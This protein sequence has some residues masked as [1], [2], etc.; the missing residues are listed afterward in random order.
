MKV[1]LVY[2]RVNKWGGAERVLLALQKIFPDAPLYTS[3]YNKQKTPWANNFYVITSFLQKIPFL[4]KHELLAPFMPIAFE[5]F[6]FDG[7][8]VVISITSESAK[9]IITK[10]HTKHICICLTPTRYL[11]SGYKEYFSSSLFR[12]ITK[13][14]V[15]Y[16]KKWDKMAS[17]RP[18]IFIAISIEVQQRIQTYYHRTSSVVYPAIDEQFLSSH[19]DSSILKKHHLTQ[20]NYFLVVSR[21]SQFT[22]Y[23]RVDQAIAAANTL[24][25]PLVIAGGGDL[26][27]FKS[28]AGKTVIFTGSIS[29]PQLKA[30]YTNAKAL[31]FPALEDFGL[32][33][34]EMQACGRPVIA[35]GKGGAV[36]IVQP[37]KTGILYKDQ[38][39]ES[40]I[41]ALKSFNEK[42]Y[43]RKYC[44]ENAKKFS[45]E[46]FKKEIQRVIQTR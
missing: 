25:L 40:L 15:W 45:F 34:A 9:G 23:K 28:L 5:Q 37:G 43:N 22:K 7:Y 13:C 39:V 21:L 20:G 31:I 33:M 42:D 2:D 38:T 3:V 4:K 41:E 46:N 29:D 6:S 24:G 35:F 11:W 27:Y 18:D 44:I 17:A 1:A 26:E 19:L 12:F 32:V 16:L 10:P 8:D 36:D 14:L 30:L